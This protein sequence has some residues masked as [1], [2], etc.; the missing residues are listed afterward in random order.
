MSVIGCNDADNT[1]N[2]GHNGAD[3]TDATSET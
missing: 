1:I 2:E 3:D